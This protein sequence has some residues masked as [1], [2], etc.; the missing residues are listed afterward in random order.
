MRTKKITHPISFYT[1]GSMSR[2]IKDFS[3]QL[4]I[5]MSDLIRRAVEDYFVKT[6]F[7]LK[8]NQ[9]AENDQEEGHGLL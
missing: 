8:R 4:G 5:S 6:G 7:N 3:D 1:T 9:S 2:A